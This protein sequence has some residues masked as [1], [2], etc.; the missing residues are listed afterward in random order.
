[1]PGKL[2]M[3]KIAALT[4]FSVSTVSRV[5]AGKPYTSDRAREAIIS[6][7][8]RLGVLDGLACGRLLIDGVAVFAPGRTFNAR[9]DVFYLE[10]TRGIAE[11]L[12][13]HNVYLSYCGLE[14]EHADIEAFLDKAGDKHI[15]AVIIIGTDDPTIFKLAAALNK[16][17]VLINT[18]DRETAL[19]AVSPDHYAI[20]FNAA[21]HVFERGHRRML[22][23]TCLRRK[24]LYTR[25]H[26]IQD[27]YRHFSVPF[28][29][30]QDVIIT[31]GF[32]PEE[33]EQALEA[34]LASH[35]PACWPEVIFPG[36]MGM[37][38]GV[39]RV[40]ARRQVQV[41]EQM[42]LMTTDFSWHLENSAGIPITGI[43]VPCRELGIEAVHLLQ[44]RLNRPQASVCHLLLQGKLRE[45]GS[46]RY[47]TRHAA[48]V[49]LGQ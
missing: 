7:A 46:V 22:S 1:M 20:G 26:G 35:P 39:L 31:E 11:A 34:W 14:E 23:L 3:D 32:S 25:L 44:H 40:L 36:S 45:A 28:D 17:C 12:A 5:L 21:R 16:P 41:P 18:H 19:D 47:A 4:G 49:A 2:Q 15:N 6:C 48:R 27:A 8:R 37:T 13:A 30:Q 24:T 43:A 33:A 9:G 38:T 42:S 10:V 29:A